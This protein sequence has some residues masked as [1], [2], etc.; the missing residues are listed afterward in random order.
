MSLQ[1][2]LS[3]RPP[4]LRQP[5]LTAGVQRGATPLAGVRGCP[6]EC[7]VAALLATASPLADGGSPEGRSPFG[8]GSG[9][10]PQSALS[11]RSSQLRHPL[12]TA[13]IQRGAAPLAGGLG[14]SPRVHNFSPFLPGRG[15]GGWCDQPL[16][17]S[18]PTESAARRS[19]VARGIAPPHCERS[20][21]LWGGVAPLLSASYHAR[22]PGLPPP[23]RIP[24]EDPRS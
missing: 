14:V 11:P 19:L 4:Q 15:P 3:P 22:C 12:L 24:Q 17:R 2:A 5:L 1:G 7:I 21:A 18:L 8:R 9:G 20:A 6:P 13:G 10:V 16:R 23:A